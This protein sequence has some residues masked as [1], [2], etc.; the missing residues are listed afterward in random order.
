MT[1]TWHYLNNTFLIVTEGSTKLMM[2]L[3]PDHR[4]RLFAQTADPDIA[5]MLATFA[6]IDDALSAAYTAWYNA[7]AFYKGATMTFEN[8]LK[9]LSKSKLD[10]WIPQ[11][12]VVFAEGTPEYST[13]FPKGRAPFTSG[14]YDMR[15]N[16]VKSLGAALASYLPLA[17]T[18]TDVDS[19][20]TNLNTAR[21]K[22]Q[23]KEEEVRVKSELL[24]TA[25]INT[26]VAMYANLGTLMAKYAATPEA[27]AKF[28]DLSLI[29]SPPKDKNTFTVIVAAKDTANVVPGGFTDTT[30]FTLYTG[31]TKGKFFTSNSAT[32]VDGEGVTLEPN[33]SKT[34]LATDLGAPGNTFLNVTNLDT[35]NQGSYSVV[36]L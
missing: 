35:L 27:I 33:T 3:S 16:A 25:R 34:V 4:A 10:S 12:Q 29:Q 24:E 11:V 15:I 1:L 14:S 7:G 2:I 31:N 9:E 19:F 13:L 36:M 5:A 23:S 30:Q 17:A 22:Q 26:G 28:F 32:G 21:T 20:F 18:K 8:Y 6:P